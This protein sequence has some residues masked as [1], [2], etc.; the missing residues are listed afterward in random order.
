M[1]QRLQVTRGRSSLGDVVVTLRAISEHMSRIKFHRHLKTPSIWWNY[2]LCILWPYSQSSIALFVCIPNLGQEVRCFGACQL[3]KKKSLCYS[4]D[5]RSLLPKL[6][7]HKYPEWIYSQYEV[8][9]PCLYFKCS[10]GVF[11]LVTLRSGECHRTP[12]MI[13]STFV[14]VMTWCCQAKKPLPQ[15][16]FQYSTWSVDVGLTWTGFTPGTLIFPLTSSDWGSTAPTTA[17]MKDHPSTITCPGAHATGLP[18]SLLSHQFLKLSDEYIPFS[19]SFTHVNTWQ[20]PTLLQWLALV[21][22]H[23]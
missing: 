18:R 6:T 11:A 13:T 9:Q 2:C 20:Y 17:N 16:I 23:I 8:R 3:I 21:H 10:K 4:Q 19:L 12:L 5:N 1:P 22:Y 14:Q 7:R 15:Q